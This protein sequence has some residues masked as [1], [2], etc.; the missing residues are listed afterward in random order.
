M[1]IL[2]QK[3]IHGGSSTHRRKRKRNLTLY[4]WA[5]FIMV[6][7]VGVTLSLTVLFRIS[8]I[9][10]IGETEYDIK[11][12]ITCSNIKS[13]DNLIRANT[14]RAQDEIQ[15]RMVYIDTAVVKR[16]FP[17]KITISVTP[18]IP[19]ANVQYGEEYILLSKSLKVLEVKKA[20]VEGLPLLVGCDADKVTPG[21]RLQSADAAKDKLLPV[22]CTAFDQREGITQ[23]DITDRFNME[24]TYEDRVIV[25]LGSQSDL[26]Y[27]LNL[28]Y[29]LVTTEIGKTKYGTLFMQGELRNGI[30][31][32]EKS[33]LERYEKNAQK[34][35]LETLPNDDPNAATV[36][37]APPAVTASAQSSKPD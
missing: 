19:Y 21:E 3:T 8:E 4:Y 33:D 13:G 7:A 16:A 26:T 35:P 20:P 15:K 18:A 10:V 37:T 36:T 27:K 28:F 6:V 2:Q 11:S 5:V 34:P 17:N 25:Q 12:I 31:F 30:S 14:I 1:E 32:V 29:K 24:A 22:I 9:N 23:V